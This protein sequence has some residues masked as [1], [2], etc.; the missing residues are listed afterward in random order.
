MVKFGKSWSATIKSLMAPEDAGAMQSDDWVPP[1][2]SMPKSLKNDIRE[3]SD[4]DIIDFAEWAQANGQSAS[5]G[6]VSSDQNMDLM[7]DQLFQCQRCG[8]CCRGPLLD[9]IAV[10]PSEVKRISAYLKMHPDKFMDRYVKTR[11]SWRHGVIPYPCPFIRGNGCSIYEI[12]PIA[13][14]TF[15]LDFQ[16]IAGCQ[17]IAVQMFCPAAKDLWIHLTRTRRDY[18]KE[19]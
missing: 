18:L 12:R 15:P 4:Q 9:G 13:C 10:L 11:R 19:A 16:M 14:R 8:K 1:R 7:M 2:I 17:E 3:M 5:L 6:M